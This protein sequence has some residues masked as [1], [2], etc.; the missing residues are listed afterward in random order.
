MVELL[1]KLRYA[2]QHS[3]ILLLLFNVEKNIKLREREKL[4]SLVVFLGSLLRAELKC[5]ETL[6]VLKLEGW[7]RALMMKL[8]PP[9][10]PIL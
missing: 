10:M 1:Q 8:L 4:V 5:R 3:D 2:E 7:Q 6:M 9:L